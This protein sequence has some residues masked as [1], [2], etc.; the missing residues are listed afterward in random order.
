MRSGA[1][2]GAAAAGTVGLAAAVN[3]AT[4]MLTQR[5]AVAWW[6]AT[7]VL[8]VIGAAVQAWLTVADRPGGTSTRDAETPGG[9]ERAGVEMRAR[10]SGHGRVSM[11][12]GDQ[13]IN[14]R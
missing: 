14:E 10:A 5:W 9:G 3:V 4:G 7:I 12:G 2:R 13:T 11:A 8:V 1:K 6:V